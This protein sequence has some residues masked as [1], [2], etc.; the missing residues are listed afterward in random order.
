VRHLRKAGH[1]PP[2][3]VATVLL[4][5][6]MW[7]S[8]TL[9]PLWFAQRGHLFNFGLSTSAMA[10]AG[11]SAFG[12]HR[13][14]VRFRAREVLVAGC[15]LY[16]AGMALRIVTGSSIVAIVS[17]VLA[18]LGASTFLVAVRI[19]V[20]RRD[21][22]E[23]RGAAT[24]REGAMQTGTVLGT[25]AASIAAAIVGRALWIGLLVAPAIVLVAAIASL[26]VEEPESVDAGTARSTA[27]APSADARIS[28]A[29]LRPRVVAVW[30]VRGFAMS[31]VVPYLPLLLERRDVPPAWIGIVLAAGSLG[32]LAVLR[33]VAVADGRFGTRRTAMASELL[34]GAI[35]LALIPAFGPWA[36]VALVLARL[37]VL[38]LTTVTQDLVLFTMEASVVLVGTAQASYLIGD[39]VAGLVAPGLWS[40]RSGVAA[41]AVCAALLVLTALANSARVLVP[42]NRPGQRATSEQATATAA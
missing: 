35:T 26:R 39:A 42:E 13:F 18:G 11:L 14:V 16:S 25:L 12:A 32:R 19:D 27:P 3:L 24:A 33:L 34:L 20:A 10:V 36:A 38:T 1:T 15:L 6:G 17:G 7:M 2:V 28:A 8:K 41:L 23:Q 4:V 21:A 40:A 5:A 22:A 31:L 29:N 30:A 37:A 9:Q